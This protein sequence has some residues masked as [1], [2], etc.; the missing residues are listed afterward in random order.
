MTAIVLYLVCINVC[1]YLLMGVDKRKARKRKSRISE[2]TL[3]TSYILG[4]AIGGYLGMKQFRH[5][6]KH[7]SFQYG[8]PLAVI[9]NVACVA[10]IFYLIK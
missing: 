8:L 3:W 10:G 9:L 7:A 2:K 1:S 6:T 5:K 4:G